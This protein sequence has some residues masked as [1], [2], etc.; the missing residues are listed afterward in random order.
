MHIIIRNSN[1]PNHIRHA[2]VAYGQWRP[3]HGG[4][5][6]PRISINA[7]LYYDPVTE[8]VEDIKRCP[9]VLLSV[10]RFPLEPDM[11]AESPTMWQSA[12]AARRC[13]FG[14]GCDGKQKVPFWHKIL[15]CLCPGTTLNLI[16][17]WTSRN[18]NEVKGHHCGKINK[19][20]SLPG[21]LCPGTQ[22]T[23]CHRNGISAPPP[24]PPTLTWSATRRTCLPLKGRD[25][26]T[27]GR[28]EQQLHT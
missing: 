18:I 2:Q 24:P 28:K 17:V 12:A 9:F 23:R 19:C 16:R 14:G 10:R 25:G 4:P 7:D 15:F 11:G 8:C 20:R 26:Q 1:S 27:E 5:Q 13:H 22:S 6:P 3:Y 21:F